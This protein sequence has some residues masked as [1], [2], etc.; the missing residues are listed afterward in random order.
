VAGTEAHE[1]GENV[2]YQTA[3]VTVTAIVADFPLVPQAFSY[4]VDYGHRAVV[5]SGDTRFSENI[6]RSARGVNVLIHEVAAASQGA[7]EN[8]PQLREVMASHTA[9]EEAG[10]VFH[11]ARPYLAVYSRQLLFGVTKREL[12]QRTRRTYRGALEIGYDLMIIEVQ[13]EVQI[14]SSPSDGRRG[15]AEVPAPGL[16]DAEQRRAQ[17]QVDAQKSQSTSAPVARWST[18]N[19]PSSFDMAPRAVPVTRTLA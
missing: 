8:S 7:L 14:R 19:D 18:T 16:G 9:P 12:L 6:V 2:A 13:N 11:A 1:I 17:Q 5:L 3:E 10:S 15:L 4:R